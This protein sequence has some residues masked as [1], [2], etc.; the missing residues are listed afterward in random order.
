M[1]IDGTIRQAAWAA[2]PVVFLAACSTNAVATGASPVALIISSNAAVKAT[3]TQ[4]REGTQQLLKDWNDAKAR[5]DEIHA[6]RLREVDGIEA[7]IVFLEEAGRLLGG[8]AEP[9]RLKTLLGLT[10][11]AAAPAL[12]AEVRKALGARTARAPAKYLRYLDAERTRLGSDAAA[13]QTFN[14]LWKTLKAPSGVRVAEAFE[15][16]NLHSWDD[17]RV[18]GFKAADGKLIDG[19]TV[20]DQLEAA[21]QSLQIDL[22]TGSTS[23]PGVLLQMRRQR[24]DFV[25]VDTLLGHLQTIARDLD[26]F[27]Q[28]DI[29]AIHW[30]DLGN[31]AGKG[32]SLAGQVKSL[33]SDR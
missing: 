24:D 31:A 8:E 29:E 21:A 25:V 1:T 30:K 20:I 32:E 18:K 26:T 33:G 15:K 10:G 11:S 3:S 27:L 6:Q 16:Q 22:P 9:G 19:K 7:D 13:M 28:N 12:D 5:I 14:A 23:Y 2:V 17:V 4:L